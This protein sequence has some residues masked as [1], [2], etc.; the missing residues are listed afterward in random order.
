MGLLNSTPWA[1]TRPPLRAEYQPATNFM[2]DFFTLFR[3]NVLLGHS[4]RLAGQLTPLIGGG[5]LLEIL[6]RLAGAGF[7]LVFLALKL[8]LVGLAGLYLVRFTR[9]LWQWRTSFGDWLRQWDGYRGDGGRWLVAWDFHSR[10]GGVTGSPWMRDFFLEE[11]KRDWQALGQFPSGIWR[12]K[13]G[14]SGSPGSPGRPLGHFLA[15]PRLAL[16]TGVTMLALSPG[17]F[18]PQWRASPWNLLPGLG[19]GWQNEVM[20]GGEKM[21][22]IPAGENPSVERGQSLRVGAHFER[23]DLTRRVR[24][25]Y[26]DGENRRQMDL[27]RNRQALRT[28]ELP[29]VLRE[30]R[31][32]LKIAYP[33]STRLAWTSEWK[34][35]RVREPGKIT[36][37]EFQIRRAG[38]IYETGRGDMILPVGARVFFRGEANRPIGRATVKF[39]N[40]GGDREVACETPEPNRFQCV[41]GF[42][43]TGGVEWYELTVWDKQDTPMA[44]GGRFSVTRRRNLRPWLRISGWKEVLTVTPEQLGILPLEVTARDDTGFSFLGLMITGNKNRQVLA[45][46]PLSQEGAKGANH[47][48]W[49]GQNVRSSDNPA[50]WEAALDLDLDW[51]AES[52]DE[53]TRIYLVGRDKSRLSENIGGLPGKL[54]WPENLPLYPLRRRSG[55]GLWALSPPFQVRIIRGMAGQL[56]RAEREQKLL[57]KMR[58]NQKKTRELEEEIAD[59]ARKVRA[60]RKVG[61]RD[62]QKLR[63]LSRELTRARR[64]GMDLVR[65]MKPAG[66]NTARA[67]SDEEGTQKRA[68]EDRLAKNSLNKNSDREER[69]IAAKEERYRELASRLDLDHQE[70]SGQVETLN[71]PDYLKSL[72][73]NIRLLE[74]LWLVRHIEKIHEGVNEF[75]EASLRGNQELTFAS[76]AEEAA[77]RKAFL[78]I[79][80]PAGTEFERL[81]R[82]ARR[83]AGSEEAKNTNLRKIITPVLRESPEWEQIL[84]AIKGLPGSAAGPGHA[85]RELFDTGLEIQR[86]AFALLEKIEQL[87]RQLSGQDLRLSL[88]ALDEVSFEIAELSRLFRAETSRLTAG[89]GSGRDYPRERLA[90]YNRLVT[91]LKESLI[92]ATRQWKETE[93]RAAVLKPEVLDWFEPEIGGLDELRGLRENKRLHHLPRVAAELRRAFQIK[94]AGLLALRQKIREELDKARGN[95][96]KGR[97][98]R[99]ARRQNKLGEGMRGKAGSSKGQGKS[100][101]KKAA[102]GQQSNQLSEKER[103]WLRTLMKQA[104]ATGRAKGDH[105]DQAGKEEPEKTKLPE[106]TR[107][108]AASG[109]QKKK[110][111]PGVKPKDGAESPAEMDDPRLVKARREFLKNLSEQ[112]LKQKGSRVEKTKDKNVPREAK[113]PVMRY[114]RPEKIKWPEEE[115]GARGRDFRSP[116]SGNYRLMGGQ[117]IFYRYY[118]QSWKN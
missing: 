116:R 84:E 106:K 110:D 115:S 81:R 17:L 68:L 5:M 77:A 35:I 2:S 49:L 107:A 31:F 15:L 37:W 78:E 1:G 43:R 91:H 66:E 102:S 62:R 32:R 44:G 90:R 82:L 25:E 45:L 7:G 30:F 65:Q 70:F 94:T 18:S 20:T 98:S 52:L 79:L 16:F 34:E 36:R 58:A 95:Y 8:V 39:G 86:D 61:R 114:A 108:T 59:L 109:P 53:D 73:Q 64:E 14:S 28:V 47:P 40:K 85:T 63:N 23:R 103:A 92:H 55:P 51:W 54:E 69:K 33:G 56:H 6:W 48:V 83:V 27:G 101:G 74:R 88:K 104:G 41:T 87:R 3:R 72:D 19:P 60:S 26:D 22:L 111:K 118:R 29:S 97:K 113:K 76:P 46:V 57:K 80:R 50:H 112:S 24:L 99:I 67:E 71:D 42:K 21:S 11:S 96:Q 10:S 13:T 89:V 117:K 105:G 75:W 100:G 4:L 93:S 12:G 38:K 9:Q